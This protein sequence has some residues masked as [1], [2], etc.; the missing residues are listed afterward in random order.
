MRCIAR[1]QPPPIA[2]Q[3]GVEGEEPVLAALTP[4][5]QGTRVEYTAGADR[6][7]PASL[8]VLRESSRERIWVGVQG[9]RSD[10][11][12]TPM[13][14]AYRAR[15]AEQLGWTEVAS[16]EELMEALESDGRGVERYGWV[17]VAV[18]LFGMAE[19]LMGL[20]FR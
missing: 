10:S 9:E 4:H 7:G 8:L 15:M 2:A 6:S 16:A 11:D 19:L 18:L 17:M 20:R 13:T 12:L 14:A 5:A 3:F 1:G